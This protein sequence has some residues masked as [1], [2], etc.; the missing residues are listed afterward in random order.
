MMFLINT[1]RYVWDNHNWTFSRDPTAS[2]AAASATTRPTT[3][4]SPTADPTP[5]GPVGDIGETSMDPANIATDYDDTWQ[6]PKGFTLIQ[7]GIAARQ[8]KETC[9]YATHCTTVQLITAGG[10]ANDL[11]VTVSS[12]DK[13]GN[14][15]GQ[16]G[17]TLGPVDAEEKALARIDTE[18]DSA[19]VKNLR[20][21]CT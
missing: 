9:R 4:P 7:P 2:P 1:V 13:A 3:A 14:I 18:P 20:V 17:T 15:L 12:Y 6:P 5:I 21:T 11:T 16:H 10:C 8:P 19:G